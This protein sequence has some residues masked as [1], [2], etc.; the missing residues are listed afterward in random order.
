MNLR[1]LLHIDLGSLLHGKLELNP[2]F[3]A[4]RFAGSSRRKPYLLSL[5][6]RIVRGVVRPNRA[7]CLRLA[8]EQLRRIVVC[9]A[10]LVPALDAIV[11]DAPYR[12]VRR[13]LC[14]LRDA[15]A[16]G[17]SLSQAMQRQPRMFPRYYVDLVRAGENTGSLVHSFDTLL[18][19]LGESERLHR[20]FVLPLTYFG[21][22]L[23]LFAAITTFLCIRVFPT[24]NAMIG[25]FGTPSPVLYRPVLWYTRLV[26][27]IGK[28]IDDS[29]SG[30]VNPAALNMGAAFAGLAVTVFLWKRGTIRRVASYALLTLPFARR[31][32]IKANLAHVARVMDALIKAGYPLDEALD[33]T[34]ACD[35]LSAFKKLVARLRDAVRRGESLA[36]ACRKESRLLPAWFCGTV[37]LGESSGDLPM[38]FERIA[39]FYQ[40]EVVASGMIVSRFV[41]PAV[42]LIMACWAFTVYSYPFIL[43]T[44]LSD[45]LI[46]SM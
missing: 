33:T 22:L 11:V 35:V 43:L 6:Q 26:D 8:T 42:V 16:A 37:S 2:D 28:A 29:I 14:R 13:T 38:A 32:V 44:V 34:V 17:H 7:R 10:P 9:N 5:P 41:L 46:S 4:S 40:R 30:V 20:A 24:L 19:M 45:T 25:D 27:T 36:D 23:L 15:V 1:D 21:V 3:Q 31:V 18:N 12:N 39:D